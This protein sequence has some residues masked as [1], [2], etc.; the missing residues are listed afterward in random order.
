[1]NEAKHLFAPLWFNICIYI[2]VMGEFVLCLPET[3]RNILC[4]IQ[5][6]PR[7]LHITVISI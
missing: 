4:F 6:S 3:W 1:M 2:E 7:Q 5:G